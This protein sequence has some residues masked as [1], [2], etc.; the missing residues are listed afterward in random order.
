[1]PRGFQANP[2]RPRRH[3][4]GVAFQPGLPPEPVVDDL[5]APVARHALPLTD[6][7]AGAQAPYAKAGLA[8]NRTEVDA[9]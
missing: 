7:L 8:I 3:L 9:R 1:M 5:M 6:F 2:G 4:R